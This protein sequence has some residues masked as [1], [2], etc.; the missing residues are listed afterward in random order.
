MIRKQFFL[1]AQAKQMCQKAWI[2]RSSGSG[3][4]FH[5]FPKG[6]NLK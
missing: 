4:G 2:K 1:I 6:N 3:K 5:T